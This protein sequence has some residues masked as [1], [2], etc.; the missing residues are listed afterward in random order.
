LVGLII[1]VENLYEGLV[2]YECNRIYPSKLGT[3]ETFYLFHHL[4]GTIY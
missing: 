2:P 1:Q 3:I 4:S